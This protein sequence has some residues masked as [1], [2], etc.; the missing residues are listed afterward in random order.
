MCVDDWYQ[1]KEQHQYNN[2]NAQNGTPQRIFLM[3]KQQRPREVSLTHGRYL[4]GGK[5]LEPLASSL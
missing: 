1:S 2:S 5:G 3:E 4:V